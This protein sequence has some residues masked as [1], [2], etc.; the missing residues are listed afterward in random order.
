MRV[1]QLDSAAAVAHDLSLFQHLPLPLQQLPHRVMAAR[2]CPHLHQTLLSPHPHARHLRYHYHIACILYS[3]MAARV[4]PHH[5]PAAPSQQGRVT[6]REAV[7]NRRIPLKT[8]SPRHRGGLGL[9]SPHFPP[10]P[11]PLALR[12]LG[13][14]Q[15][16][17]HET[18]LLQCR[19]PRRLGVHGRCEGHHVKR[20]PAQLR[21]HHLLMQAP[22]VR[23][24][25]LGTV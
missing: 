5:Q 21:P 17:L 18:P 12:R 24:H 11:P 10:R 19:T 14:R 15:D 7:Q 6:P 1:S 22:K 16:H 25:P 8:G 13:R 23:T 20:L 2:V 9:T 3:M 4:D